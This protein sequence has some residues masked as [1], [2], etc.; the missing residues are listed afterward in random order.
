MSTHSDA[1]INWRCSQLLTHCWPR[2][3]L[4]VSRH[5]RLSIKMLIECQLTVNQGV[6]H[7]SI[8]CCPRVIVNHELIYGIN[9]EYWSTLERRCVKYTWSNFCSL[10]IPKNEEITI[11]CLLPNSK[12]LFLLL[13][14]NYNCRQKSL[15]HLICNITNYLCFTNLQKTCCRPLPTQYNVEN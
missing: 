3:W 15:G 5:N 12:P 6:H 1:G 9:W 4:S 2:C 11:R 8:E 7:V 10:M 13:S 14:S